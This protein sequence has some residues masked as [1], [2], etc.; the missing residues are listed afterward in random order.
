MSSVKKAS[1]TD[2]GANR[3]HNVGLRLTYKV[4]LCLTSMNQAIPDPNVKEGA[5]T[6]ESNDKPKQVQY[7]FMDD[8]EMNNIV[9][10]DCTEL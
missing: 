6:S 5:A 3:M 10:R 8:P 9:R 1:V 4:S 2:A 7:Q